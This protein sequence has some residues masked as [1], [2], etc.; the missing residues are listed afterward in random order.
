MRHKERPL[1]EFL[2]L[3]SGIIALNMYLANHNYKPIKNKYLQ[4]LGQHEI[5]TRTDLISRKEMCILMRNLKIKHK[6][7]I[8]LQKPI[9]LKDIPLS[10]CKDY[11]LKLE[12][13]Y[14]LY[15]EHNVYYALYDMRQELIIEICEIKSKM[16]RR[17][18]KRKL[19]L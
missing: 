11:L 7:F 1:K 18:I 6:R 2:D 19:D 17:K 4:F 9:T 8:K 15:M 5:S 14:Y 10:P 3:P 12:G 13:D 16:S